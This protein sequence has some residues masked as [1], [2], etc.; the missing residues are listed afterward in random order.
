MLVLYAGR[1]RLYRLLPAADMA[2]LSFRD[3]VL[4]DENDRPYD[5]RVREEEDE[6]AGVGRYREGLADGLHV[7][8]KNNRLR[9]VGHWRRGKLDGAF[10][11]FDANGVLTEEDH[12]RSGKRNGV[13]RQYDDRG[14]IRLEQSYAQGV[15]D[16]VSRQYYPNGRIYIHMNY[17]RGIPDGYY[18]MYEDNGRIIVEAVLK[19]GHFDSV[20]QYDPDYFLPDSLTGKNGENK[21]KAGD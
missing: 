16:G 18:A 21:E 4:V 17:R 14:R 15:L 2:A 12:Y 13:R 20:K 19:D 7:L 8:Y 11:V 6:Y 10:L 5:G 3:G 1:Y 9:Q